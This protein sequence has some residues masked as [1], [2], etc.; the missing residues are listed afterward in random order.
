MVWVQSQ[1][2]VYNRLSEVFQWSGESSDSQSM[3]PIKSGGGRERVVVGI[4]MK[5]Q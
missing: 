1:V 3:K 5:S 4:R 2:W